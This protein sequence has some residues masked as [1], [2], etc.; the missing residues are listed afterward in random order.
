[1]VKTRKYILITIMLFMVLTLGVGVS[2]WNIHYKVSFDKPT[3][4]FA[5][6]QL[7]EEDK[8]NV[9]VIDTQTATEANTALIVKDIDVSGNIT[10]ENGSVTDKISALEMKSHTITYDGEGIGIT[11]T[12]KGDAQGVISSWNEWDI[13]FNMEY[14]KY[15]AE[16]KTFNEV[17]ET[18]T[19]TDAGS[20]RAKI[21]AVSRDQNNP[22]VAKINVYGGN[23][24]LSTNA[25][26]NDSAN[27]QN[28]T[29]ALALAKINVYDGDGNPVDANGTYCAFIDFEIKPKPIELTWS[30][31][32]FTY[33]GQ[34]QAPTAQITSGV[35]DEDDVSKDATITITQSGNKIESAK[36]AGDYTATATLSGADSGNYSITNSTKEFTIEQLVAQIEW[37]APANLVYDGTAKTPTA[38]VKNLVDGDTCQVTT[39][40]ASGNGTNV[41]AFTYK[42]TDLSNANYKL[43]E[44]E[45][46]P[47]YT[48]LPKPVTLTW[49]APEYLVYD[50]TAK[51]PTVV[52]GNLVSDDN[53]TA[54]IA[55]TAGND[56][57]N[58]GTFTFTAI[59]L[60]N[61]ELR[62]YALPTEVVSPEYTITAKSVTLTW[63][64]T[65]FTYDG[66]AKKP[67]ATYVDVT[68][69]E[70][71][72]VIE[73]TSPAGIESAIDAGTYKA[74]ATISNTNYAISGESDR[75][76]IINKAEVTLTW[77][78]GTYTYNG[79]EQKPTASIASGLVSGDTCTVT[80]KGAKNAGTHTAKATLSGKDSDNY[81]IENDTQEF[82]IDRASLTITAND[83]TVSAGMTP[84][85]TVTYT[86]FVNGE[87]EEVLTGTLAFE[88]DY[89]ATVQNPQETYT[90]RPYGLESDNYQITYINGTLTVSSD[91]IITY[92][93]FSA[94]FTYDGTAHDL[95]TN[96]TDI[97]QE[98]DGLTGL[99]ITL[100]GQSVTDLTTSPTATNAGKYAIEITLPAG[101]KWSDN[102]NSTVTRTVTVAKRTLS[103]TISATNKTIVYGQ[104]IDALGLTITPTGLQGTDTL[105]NNYNL[106]F[107][108]TSVPPTDTTTLLNAGS[109]TLG[110]ELTNDTMKNN[111]TV[112]VQPFGITVD[113]LK[114]ALNG[115]IEKDYGNT[116]VVD[117]TALK[118]Y[119]VLVNAE[120][121]TVDYKSVITIG[122]ITA[123][124]YLTNDAANDNK[125]LIKY[126]GTS[127]TITKGSTYLVTA[128]A[129]SSNT[130]IEF[131]ANDTEHSLYIKY[132]TAKV[133]STYYTIE[134]ALTQ[135]GEIILAS[136][137]SKN[138]TYVITAFSKLG[139]YN[140]DHNYTTANIIKLPYS[141]DTTGT[142]W[143]T[144]VAASNV[145]SVLTIPTGVTLNTTKNIEI[146]A[147][148]GNQG[149]V[150]T[151]AV[152]MNHGTININGATIKAHGYLK[153]SGV[154][155]LTNATVEDI[156]KTFD[157]KGGGITYGI[158][159]KTKDY[160]PI[161]AYSLHN[162]SCKTII[163]VG[164]TY[165]A[166]Y[167]FTMA[168]QWF[169]GVVNIIANTPLA[170][171]KL[172]SG[173]IEK[174]G[175]NLTGNTELDTITGSNQLAGQKEVIKVCGN[176]TDGTVIVEVSF[177]GQTIS[178][179]T[180][181]NNP[182]PVPYMEIHIG[183][184]T[185][186]SNLTLSTSSYKFMPGSSVIVHEGSTLTTGG[187]TQLIFYT[188][189]QATQA[190]TVTQFKNANGTEATYPYIYMTKYC[191]D[192]VDSY[193]EVN[194]KATIN[195][196]ISGTIKSSVEGAQFIANKVNTDITV[197]DT[198]FDDDELLF[199]VKYAAVTT[200]KTSTFLPMTAQGNLLTAD[201]TVAMGNLQASVVY[202][203]KQ[204]GEQYY[205]LS[206]ANEKTI[207][208]NHNDGTGNVTTLPVAL[209][210]NADGTG[211]IYVITANDIPNIVRE[212]Y[213][214]S[215]WFDNNN[216]K[217]VPDVTTISD[218]AIFTARWTP[219][220]YTITYQYFTEDGQKITTG[221]TN[222][223]QTTYDFG[224]TVSLIAPTVDTATHPNLSFIGWFLD[225]GF[226]QQITQI[227]STDFGNK[228]IYGKFTNQVIVEYHVTV[229]TGRTDVTMDTAQ[230]QLVL[231]GFETACTANIPNF[232]VTWNNTTDQ[233]N[234]EFLN[235]EY[236]FDSYFVS[237]RLSY[238][239]DG[240]AQTVEN[241]ALNGQI[242]IP[243]GAT[244]INLTAQWTR[245]ATL[246]VLLC[247]TKNTK[248]KSKVFYFMPSETALTHNEIDKVLGDLL[249]NYEFKN[250]TYNGEPDT[251]ITFEG[252]NV[253]EVK[254]YY[255]PYY[256]INIIDASNGKIETVRLEPSETTYTLAS[257]PNPDNIKY[258][259]T[260]NTSD[261]SISNETTLKLPTDTYTE[262]N[263]TRKEATL[264][265]IYFELTNA[266]I[267]V[268]GERASSGS[269]ELT[270]KYIA[271]DVIEFRVNFT[272][273]DNRNWKIT[274][275]S[276]TID[277]GNAAVT[278]REFT[279][280]ESNVTITASSEDNSCF[281]EG[282]LI[283]LADGTK[284]KV[285]LITE[286]DILLVFNHETGK[287][288]FAKVLFN[289]TEPQSQY[290][291]I[292]LRFAN[293]KLVKVVSEHGF[294]DLTL[295]KYVYIDE[296]NYAD[297]V[298][299][300]FYQA[301]W[302]GTDYISSTTTLANA[303]LTTENVKVYS[304]VTTYHMNYFTEDLLSMP[305][306][307]EGL[308]NIFEYDTN[309]QYNK[310]LMQQDIDTYGLFTYDDFKDLVPIEIYN[311]FPAQYFKVAMGKN[312]LTWEQ[313]NYYIER[314]APL[315]IED[316][317]TDTDNA[318][319]NSQSPLYQDD[320]VL[321]PT[322]S[323]RS[324]KDE[325]EE[326]N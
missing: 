320:Q 312:L 63:S 270:K 113:K 201:N 125:G 135:S 156:F 83:V 230:S 13:G 95:I 126:S 53:I 248:I 93:T 173:Y 136:N 81:I 44:N 120:T 163:N 259:Y 102:T 238:N 182:L 274:D 255:L 168:S 71:Q 217:L 304:P 26:G 128:T 105:E 32:T 64:N 131:V 276:G 9:N 213:V 234:N 193:L 227:S 290:T 225:A 112:Q 231:R 65:T 15:D 59:G 287:Y 322:T 92:P 155:N 142:T 323:G 277:S 14:F 233:L 132:K 35:L 175:A 49:K 91:K 257:S 204:S 153:G 291:V 266:T 6:N 17:T 278:D 54:Q 150:T 265:T 61:N 286:N 158:Y 16:S 74:T 179:Q 197:L 236:N 307:I 88:C 280:R 241:I 324:D 127:F 77:S 210:P 250:Y 232:E 27:D 50:G 8:N 86:G 311:A 23:G 134:D 110:I 122:T 21:K 140:T 73:I 292:N 47:P 303:Y 183:D 305:G 42:A 5:E 31:T 310:E 275:S 101:C 144:S 184:G 4:E 272:E 11:V 160:F 159:D 199:I 284:K 211:Y 229:N 318:Q 114:V 151:R 62:N 220:K 245:K 43:L 133:G 24:T 249:E 316:A 129:T 254:A 174:S 48:I 167:Q 212:H 221:I 161:N 130:N 94:D 38:T 223:N 146:Y 189:D 282:T 90:I 124:N 294:F 170:L 70:Q 206:N 25:N 169:D 12:A 180:G 188:V 260:V 285:E 215:G 107:G 72:A 56:N 2:K 219:K 273:P 165:T 37:T 98:I 33:N 52:V 154:I 283:T 137:S 19:P 263:V 209:Y 205:W 117:G 121:T 218:N 240:T 224:D 298:G 147:V 202:K 268:N 208:F 109:Y 45:T 264:Y 75:T 143:E 235:D 84:N 194:G 100:N 314:Y 78:V 141:A 293:G 111:Y 222:E 166:T 244:D 326:S 67:T 68:G 242:E 313:L 10:S 119:L 29:T 157:F 191:I 152:I 89:S 243:G 96:F 301:T 195:G 176:A 178:M 192:K 51:I 87:T 82:T 28:D 139:Y 164:S 267:E 60:N 115:L 162:V 80:V 171:F 181:T 253:Y 309:L 79:Q 149:S 319:D 58:V 7:Q 216:N 106:K 325:Q 262:I 288:D 30:D 22:A 103:I 76:F 198:V 99:T 246:N 145:G 34:H 228:V 85:Y 258:V 55:L 281:I 39:A 108:N 40:L 252:S 289:D 118:N 279:M 317:G 185:N 251:S 271:G 123:K 269:G 207:T 203:S 138:N 308:F 261:A 3:I 315:M 200:R 187:S 1:M 306:G 69:T 247:D 237:W 256:T 36:N 296:T 299:H 177:L 18:E 239:L 97:L 186:H 295:N 226:T 300:T 172:S 297:F 57:V 148:I 116:D 41:G 104:T 66:N 302:N 321:L 190:E 214:F 46:S 196:S 20:Y